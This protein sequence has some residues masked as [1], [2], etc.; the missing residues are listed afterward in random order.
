MRM[1]VFSF[2]RRAVRSLGDCS[3]LY[4]SFKGVRV[5][6]AGLASPYESHR[7]LWF[8]PSDIAANVLAAANSKYG[9]IV[10]FSPL[11]ALAEDLGEERM[12][13]LW[14][15]CI[16][17][18]IYASTW[19]GGRVP[20]CVLEP[21]LKRA[22]SLG[23]GEPCDGKDFLYAYAVRPLVVGW[24]YG[25]PVCPLATNP[26]NR[27]GELPEG[28]EGHPLYKPLRLNP[29][30]APAALQGSLTAF[31]VNEELGKLL[32]PYHL[33]YMGPGEWFYNHNNGQPTCYAGEERRAAPVY[34]AMVGDHLMALAVV[35]G[36]TV[37]YSPDHEHVSLGEGTYLLVHP[38][39]QGRVD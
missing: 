39:P 33:E 36:P 37:L 4:M 6:A 11:R 24:H 31:R 7:Q 30:I 19:A 25:R 15:E 17:P 18:S 5:R 12:W 27:L 22:A 34:G 3:T 8:E 29:A 26:V 23:L 2:V 14:R 9:L 13:K 35:G 20:R 10:S 32:A 28:A 38:F 1:D 16:S 21:V